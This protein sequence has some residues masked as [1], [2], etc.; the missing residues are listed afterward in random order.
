MAAVQ[1]KSTPVIACNQLLVC[2]MACNHAAMI[3]PNN[4][5]E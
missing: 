3:R 1:L 4:K 2:Y 5:F